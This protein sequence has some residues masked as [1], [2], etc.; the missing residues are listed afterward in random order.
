MRAC[1][2]CGA[3]PSTEGW[4]CSECGWR[5]ST[6]DGFLAFAPEMARTDD[7]F[8]PSLFDG[9]ADVEARNF[10]FSA[11][12]DLILWAMR[13]HVPECTRF[14]E[15][16]CGTGFVLAGIRSAYPDAELVGSEIYTAGLGHAARRIPSATLYQM[17]ARAIPFSNHFDAIGAFDVLEHVREDATVIAEVTRA[18]RPGG[19][20]LVTVPQHPALWSPQDEHAHHVRRYTS[21]GL[22]RQLLAA[23]LEV[24]RMTSFVTL[25]LPF[26]VASRVRL[27]AP[28]RERPFDPIDE[29]R[30]PRLANAAF[31]AVMQLEGLFTKR[32]L[33]WPAGGSLLAVARKPIETGRA[34]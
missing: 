9:L 7:G 16:G 2:S 4:A 11:R 5:P 3:T 17:D 8:D 25:L 15:I 34:A 6:I 26:M 24:T 12:N 32:G 28:S 30:T 1:P 13:T 23:G 20:F 14:L 21:A 18:L 31:R 33:A 27:R 19:H 10:W 29:L 22:R